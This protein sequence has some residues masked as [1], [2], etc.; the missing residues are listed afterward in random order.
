MV[1]LEN[2]E[3]EERSCCLVEIFI[4]WHQALGE[5]ETRIRLKFGVQS[6]LVICG[7]SNRRFGVLFAPRD[8]SRLPAEFPT[9][10]NKR[11]VRI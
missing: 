5:I 3:L 7:C 1:C 6:L 9:I 4:A 8:F 2:W 11:T 10:L